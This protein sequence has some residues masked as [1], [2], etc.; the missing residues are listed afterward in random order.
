M[1]VSR[2]YVSE[3]VDGLQRQGRYTFTLSELAASTSANARPLSAAITR[4]IAKGRLRRFTARG[5]FFII[6]PLEYYSL[7]APPVAWVLEDYMRHLGVSY[8]VGLLSAAEWHGSAHFAVQE[9]QVVVSKQIRSAQV[10]RSRV[11]FVVKRAAGDTPVETRA[12]EAGAVRVST[13]EATLLDMVR[14]RRAVGGLNRIA[15]VAADIGLLCHPVGMQTAL[16]AANDPPSA[17]RLGFLLEKLDFKA[18]ADV[19]R[20]WI[21]AHRH[22]VCALEFALPAD[23]PRRPDWDIV[24]NV[25]IEATL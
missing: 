5:D 1:S 4:L 23:G 19:A 22:S 17:Q 25:T 10:G 11:H 12:T 16:D 8:Y 21:A 3:F 13:V 2:G 6:V 18:P 7:G 14:Y 15:T 20:R 24:E 9:T